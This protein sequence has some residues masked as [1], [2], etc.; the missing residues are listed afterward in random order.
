MKTYFSSIFP[1]VLDINPLELEIL[2]LSKD[3]LHNANR[4]TYVPVFLALYREE[5]LYCQVDYEFHFLETYDDWKLLNGK[6]FNPYFPSE[7]ELSHLLQY[8]IKYHLVIPEMLSYEEVRL[9]IC[10]R[11]EDIIKNW[12]R[13][14]KINDLLK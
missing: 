7:D 6:D 12:N 11:E 5:L 2:Y 10:Q 14:K 3:L 8:K 9:Q 13:D 1:E 4:T